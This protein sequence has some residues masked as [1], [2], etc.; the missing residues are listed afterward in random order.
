MGPN[1]RDFTKIEQMIVDFY[2][3][4]LAPLPDWI[5][6]IIYL[7]VGFVIVV[8]LFSFARKFFKFFLI[9]M[10]ILIVIAVAVFIY[11]S[12]LNR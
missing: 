4:Y 7:F 1:G 5:E 2:T 10:A 11:I 12:I 8:G 9:V 6:I 3:T